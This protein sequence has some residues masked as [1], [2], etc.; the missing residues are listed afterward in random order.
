MNALSY[1]L[2]LMWTVAVFFFAYQFIMRLTSGLVMPEFL[3]GTLY[4]GKPVSALID[5]FC[6][7]R[8]N[9]GNVRFGYL[10]MG[11]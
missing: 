9:C 5:V 4:E 8:S 1:K 2:W 3:M 7:C 6:R 11:K 10:G